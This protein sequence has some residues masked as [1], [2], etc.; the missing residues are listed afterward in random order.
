MTNKKYKF[1]FQKDIF[2][3]DFDIDER[4]YKLSCYAHE[5]SFIACFLYFLEK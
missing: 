3:H 5:N 4:H 1:L 2:L